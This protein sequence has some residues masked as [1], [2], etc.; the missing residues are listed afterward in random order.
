MAMRVMEG[1]ISTVFNGVL[2]LGL[3]GKRDFLKQTSK[4]SV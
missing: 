3:R 2:Q 4:G 1:D